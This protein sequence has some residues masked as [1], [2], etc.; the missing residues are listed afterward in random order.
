MKK[1]TLIIPDYNDKEEMIYILYRE[2]CAVA[3]RLGSRE[4]EK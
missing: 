3:K 1:I 2:L 4:T